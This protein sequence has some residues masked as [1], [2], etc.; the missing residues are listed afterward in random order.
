MNIRNKKD[1]S[2]VIKRLNL[3]RV[4]CVEFKV[5]DNVNK[6]VIEY[7]LNNGDDKTLW[8]IRDNTN[9]SGKFRKCLRASDIESIEFSGI[10]SISVFESMEQY[11]REHMVIQGDIW[12]DNEYNVIATLSTKKGYTLRDAT[13]CADLFETVKYNFVA[14]K[15]P[16]KY[17][18]YVDSIVDLICEKGIV[19]SIV[20]FTMYDIPVGINSENVVIWEIR[21]R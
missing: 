15:C 11:D 17:R 1:S 7:M 2:E 16:I 21:N 13:S 18:E 12:V 6:K 9:Y 5:D 10:D 19:G 8:N 20:E 3:N 14:D 4:K